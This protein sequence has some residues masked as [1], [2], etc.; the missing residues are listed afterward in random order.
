MKKLII[1]LVATTL[2]VGVAASA[3]AQTTPADKAAATG[4]K[5]DAKAD[6]KVAKADDKAAKTDAKADATAGKKVAKANTKKAK[7]EAKGD[8]KGAAKADASADKAVAKADAT[9]TKAGAKAK[10]AKTDAKA[11]AT[12]KKADAN[13]DAA[14][15]SARLKPLRTHDNA[16]ALS[17]RRVGRY[18]NHRRQNPLRPTGSSSSTG[19]A[20]QWP[21][22]SRTSPFSLR[23]SD[24]Q[25]SAPLA[26]YRPRL[27]C[28]HR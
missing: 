8:T 19:C 13:A 22:P 26:R 10:K 28:G 7:A 23:R 18:P 16:V 3:I 27:R 14:K 6:K 4:A 1:A 24:S 15:K 12:K 17:G 25:A 5:A 21:P 9:N 20:D 11:D 2:T